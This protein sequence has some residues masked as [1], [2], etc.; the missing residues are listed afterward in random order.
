M[1]GMPREDRELY[2]KIGEKINSRQPP[3]KIETSPFFE[4]IVVG[5]VGFLLFILFIYF[6]TYCSFFNVFSCLVS[7][8]P[9]R[10]VSRSP[11]SSSSLPAATAAIS[12]MGK[13]QL[14]ME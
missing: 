6:F 2:A 13:V 9:S 14:E 8:K 3:F 7:F 10:L 5:M 12:S 1:G 4:L 11:S